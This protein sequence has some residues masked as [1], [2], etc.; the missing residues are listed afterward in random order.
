[1]EETRNIFNFVKASDDQYDA[2]HGSSHCLDVLALVLRFLY[3]IGE[4]VGLTEERVRLIMK[5]ATLLHEQK[6]RKRA[7]R[8]DDEAMKE[9]MR[10]D[11]LTEEEINIVN[12]LITYCS[13]SKSNE[14]GRHFPEMKKYEPMMRLLSS[15]D[16]AE[17]VNEK[18]LF[19]SFE[20]HKTRM[21][22]EGKIPD[23]R[24]CWENV[25]L[26]YNDPNNGFFVRLNAISI[27]EV[28]ESLKDT[29]EETDR[30]MKEKVK[31]FCL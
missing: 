6:D 23:E 12:W 31:E 25:H 3:T 19:R 30:R 10:L 17:A 5:A 22:R 24:A 26:F 8:L 20:Y 7:R 11:G 18:A 21:E 9:S 29:L 4:I 16:L 13:F 28:R 15:A 2:A 14:P 1:M 27:S